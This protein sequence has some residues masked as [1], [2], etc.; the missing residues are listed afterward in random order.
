M[1]LFSKGKIILIDEVDGVAG[2]SDRGGISALSAVIKKSSFPIIMTANDPFHK[3]F[4]SL[5][6][7]SQMI[8]F[9]TLPYTVIKSILMEICKKEE[10]E[11]DETALTMLARYANGD[12]RAGITDLQALCE[13]T[14]KLEKKDLE[15]VFDR[16]KT[17]TMIDA[18][19]RIFKSTKAS[20]ILPALD[21]VDEDMDQF[22]FWIDENLPKEYTK[23]KDLA[24]AYDNI[25]LADVFKGRIRKWQYW[26]YLVYVKLLLTA[27]VGLAKEEKYPGFNKYTKT[28]R[29]LKMWQANMKNM[30][31]KSI[32]EKI[33]DVSH[34]ST[35]RAMH[36]IYPY[37]KL[38]FQ[39]SKEMA[40]TIADDLELDDGEI[41][42]LKR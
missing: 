9:S 7:S 21:N 36:D 22:F 37:L 1:S 19:M 29:I 12:L 17:E 40:I 28:T 30:K 2:N 32:S 41:A 14:K 23:I 15:D 24:A 35:K 18:L 31:K 10:I 38:I 20:V 6:K 5:R 33:S 39:N 34:T 3:K 4:S 27:G 26:R 13:S 11:Y 16:E 8:E 25:S 42:Y